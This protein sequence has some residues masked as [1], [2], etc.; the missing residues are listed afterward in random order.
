M[1]WMRD[2]YKEEGPQISMR[3]RIAGCEEEVAERSPQLLKLVS[4][5]QDRAGVEDASIEHLDVFYRY[6]Q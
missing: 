4:D 5:C 1:E 2:E 3:A 6:L